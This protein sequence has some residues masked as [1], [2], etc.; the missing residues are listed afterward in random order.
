MM[1]SRKQRRY[2]QKMEIILPMESEEVDKEEG[3]HRTLAEDNHSFVIMIREKRKTE[4]DSKW[5]ST[6]I[7]S[8]INGIQWSKA[9]SIQLFIW[10]LP[11]LIIQLEEWEKWTW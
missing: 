8:L 5:W 2:K 9:L 4:K 6:C 7:K 1:T 3:E 11:L 10:Y